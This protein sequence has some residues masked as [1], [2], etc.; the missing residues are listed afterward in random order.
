MLAVFLPKSKSIS[1]WKGNTMSKKKHV[2]NKEPNKLPITRVFA[3]LASSLPGWWMRKENVVYWQGRWLQISSNPV[4]T[5][6]DWPEGDTFAW[7][8]IEEF[9]VRRDVAEFLQ[10]VTEDSDTELPWFDELRKLPFSFCVDSVVAEL[11]HQLNRPPSLNLKG[12]SG[13]A[14]RLLEARA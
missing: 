12:L 3:D 2:T 7:Q 9:Q 8:Q 13:A 1:I 6:H 14:V 4:D 10:A 11:K 5:D